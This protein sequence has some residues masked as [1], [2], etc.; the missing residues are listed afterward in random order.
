MKRRCSGAQCVALLIGG[1]SQLID[2]ELNRLG[3]V[4]P[5]YSKSKVADCHAIPSLQKLL[6]RDYVYFQECRETWLFLVLA[7]AISSL[8]RHLFGLVFVALA[9]GEY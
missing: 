2:C 1:S 7:L 4:R 5:E 9:H 8:P 3:C 6:Q